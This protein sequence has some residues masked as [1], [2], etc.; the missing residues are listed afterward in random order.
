MIKFSETD[1][2]SYRTGDIVDEVNIVGLPLTMEKLTDFNKKD[3]NKD[4]RKTFSYYRYQDKLKCSNI[5]FKIFQILRLHFV[6]LR[7]D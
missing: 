3:V 1:N 7:R 2:E 5:Y 6:L 4:F